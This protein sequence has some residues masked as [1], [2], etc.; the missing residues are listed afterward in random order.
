MRSGLRQATLAAAVVAVGIALLTVAG[1]LAWARD[2]PLEDL[3]SDPTDV[4]GLGFAVGALTRLEVLVWSA[5]A[6]IAIAAG[7]LGR[8][9]SLPEASVPLAFGILAGIL[10]ADDALLF[11][12]AAAEEAGIPKGSFQTLYGAVALV[13]LW[14]LR[15]PLLSRTP[16]MLLVVACGW[17]ALS[18]IS[19]VVLDNTSVDSAELNFAED[20]MKLLGI[21]TWSLYLLLVS[22]DLVLS[23]LKPP[24]R[25]QPLRLDQPPLKRA[26]ERDSTLGVRP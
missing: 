14:R 18:G 2:I 5:A 4:T 22:R 13:L 15:A 23:L 1:A 8:R 10:V 25:S 20:G 11:H 19:D 6:G 24:P 26:A 16:W 7:L 21:L 12:E 3:A 17:L 9:W